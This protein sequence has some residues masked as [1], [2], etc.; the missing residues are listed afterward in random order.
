M[1][2]EGG[3]RLKLN[4]GLYLNKYGSVLVKCVAALSK[5]EKPMTVSELRQRL[6]PLCNTVA[7]CDPIRVL[8]ELSKSS[9]SDTDCQR[10]WPKQIQVQFSI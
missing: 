9:G 3:P 10:H 5:D 6:E 7:V 2:P 1:E 4:R 8:E